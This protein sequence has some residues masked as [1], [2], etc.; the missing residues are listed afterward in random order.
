MDRRLGW[1]VW[2]GA[3]AVA[4]YCA[5][6]EQSQWVQ[7]A[8]IAFVWYMLVALLSALL[9]GPASRHLEGPLVQFASAMAFDLAV[10]AAMFLAHWYWTAFAYAASCGCVALMAVRKTS[11][12]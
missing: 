1:I 12:P 5:L 9:G 11:G 4:L 3:F 8:L 10:L 7:Y 6:V 2:K